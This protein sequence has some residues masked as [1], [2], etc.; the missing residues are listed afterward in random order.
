MDPITVSRIFEPFFTTKGPGKG[1]GLGLATVYGIVRQAGG[2]IWVYSEPGRGTTFKIYLPV[3]TG[4][5]PPSLPHSAAPPRAIAS[6]SVLVVED[7][8]HVRSMMVEALSRVGYQ[9]RDVASGEEALA[10]AGRP[11]PPPQLL[12]TDVVLTGMNGR[13]I[14]SRLLEIYP[15]MKVLYTSGY[16]DNIIVERGVLKPGVRFL[17]KPFGPHALCEK[18]RQVLDEAV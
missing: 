12:V 15:G 1:T 9:V 2:G 14:A 18:V 6:E 7:Q 11:G 16:T 4:G 5:A 10:L 3:H 17:S 8:D 13:E